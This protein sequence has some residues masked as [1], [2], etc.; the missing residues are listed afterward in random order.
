MNVRV[1]A[2]MVAVAAMVTFTSCNQPQ[3]K[4]EQTQDKV[5]EMN[6]PGPQ[7]GT[8]MT[9][10]YVYQMGKFMYVYVGVAHGKRTQPHTGHARG[11]RTRA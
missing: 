6:V 9:K 5:E 4:P 2:F 10:E 7:S 11:A 8:I 1:A 3:S